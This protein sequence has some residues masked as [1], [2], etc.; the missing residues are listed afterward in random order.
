[1]AL[2]PHEVDTESDEWLAMS[3][4]E[5]AAKYIE[6]KRRQDMEGGLR[7][8]MRDMAKEGGETSKHFLKVTANGSQGCNP[9][10]PTAHLCRTISFCHAFTVPVFITLYR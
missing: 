7:R 8:A 3:E 5:R 10:S 4:R 2:L 6:G 9:V 1:M